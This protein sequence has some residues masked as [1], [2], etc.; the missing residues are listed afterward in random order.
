MYRGIA[1]LLSCIALSGCLDVTEIF[2]PAHE[3]VN[4]AFPLRSEARIAEENIRALLLTNQIALKSFEARRASQLELRALSCTQ[5]I[6]IGR[7][8]SISTVRALPLS[9]DC[10]A[11]QDEKFSQYLGVYHVGALIAQPPLHPLL[12]LG[13][14]VAIP[15]FSGT[16]MYSADAA[17]AAGVVVARGIQG[18]F[19]SIEIPGG[20]K[21]AHFRSV[22]TPSQS[23]YLSPN[24]R[25]AAIQQGNVGLVF[26]DTESGTKLWEI[27]G[28]SRI[29]TWMPEISAALVNNLE[30][31]GL[32]IIDFQTNKIEP[33]VV[34]PR[35]STWAVTLQGNSVRQ[36]VGD[37]KSFSLIEHVR[38]N[39]GILGVV[40]KEYRIN[41]GSGVTSLPPTLMRGDKAIIFI[42]ARDFMSIELETGKESIWPTG[43]FLNTRYAKLNDSTL[44]VDS[45]PIN[46]LGTRSWVFDI[47]QSTLAPVETRLAGLGLLSG[48]AG[49]SGFMRQNQGVWLGDKVE[50]GEPTSMESLRASYNMERQLAQLEAVD[51]IIGHDPQNSPAIHLAVNS[52]GTDCQMVNLARDAQVEAIGVY[53]GTDR[54]GRTT[55]DG[56]KQGHVEV[57][58]R[59]SP[60]A[61]V[62]ILSSYEPVRWVLT[63]EP[64]ARIAAVLVSGYYPSEVVGAGRARIFNMG[65]TFAYKLG[66]AE[67][68]ALNRDTIMCIGKPI[69]AFQGRYDGTYFVVGG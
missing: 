47:E 69:D 20:K 62:L 44:L 2:L 45:L 24:G 34:A 12:P 42:S 29:L 58:V 46:R 54:E 21:I 64:G 1:I 17:S 57:H 19:F 10:L 66:S 18:E 33:Y 61:K 51:A 38:T 8:D 41:Q 26:F 3:K 67:H 28:A 53:Q 63:S 23:V 35:N 16:P 39:E 30:K 55:K 11:D 49:R 48:L 32:S 4:R 13:L 68:R 40:L 7:W 43:D 6:S 14:P 5:G 15:N 60:K 52:P 9:R 50:T 36:L 27:K 31:G 56:R 25:V 65:R 37:Q 22:P 59:R